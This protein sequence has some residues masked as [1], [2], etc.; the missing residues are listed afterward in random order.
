MGKGPAGERGEH[1]VVY[2][3]GTGQRTLDEFLSL[4]VLH[5]IETLIDVRRYPWSRF[6]HFRKSLLASELEKKNIHYLYLG[7]TLGGFREKGYEEHMVSED[8]S[9]GLEELEKASRVSRAAFF[10]AETLPWRCHRRH[11]ARCLIRR[12]WKVVHILDEGRTWEE[13]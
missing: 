10:C 12:G 8:F 4:L 3:I 5:G 11:I 6:E 9:R 2:T 7:E 1:R 13:K